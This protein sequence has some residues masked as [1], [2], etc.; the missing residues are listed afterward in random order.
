MECSLEYCERYCSHFSLWPFQQQKKEG[1]LESFLLNFCLKTFLFFF[2]L[3]YRKAFQVKIN[4]FSHSTQL[5]FFH[6]FRSPLD[7]FCG[8]NFYLLSILLFYKCYDDVGPNYVKISR[9]CFFVL[10]FS[11]WCSCCSLI[12]GTLLWANSN[13]C[14]F[15]RCR[16]IGIFSC[17]LEYK[18]PCVILLFQSERNRFQNNL[19]KKKVVWEQLG[20]T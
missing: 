2:P 15:Q 13:V 11:E 1:F 8:V 4:Q 16:K 10:F 19:W 7:V 6:F 20:L 9:E 12:N 5:L 17:W 3:Q 18:L 14:I